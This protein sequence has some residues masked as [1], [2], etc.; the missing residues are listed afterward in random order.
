MDTGHRGQGSFPTL[1]PVGILLLNQ[2]MVG[3]GKYRILYN[4]ESN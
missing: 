3:D 4:R 1:I 2:N